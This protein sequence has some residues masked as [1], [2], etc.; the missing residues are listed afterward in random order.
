MKTERILVIDDDE[1]ARGLLQ[2]VLEHLGYRVLLA[3]SGLEA[4][5][6]FARQSEEVDLVILDL[7]MPVMSGAK[8]FPQLRAM[9]PGVPIVVSSGY[10]KSEA[11][12]RCGS[13]TDGFLQ[14]PFSI[15]QLAQAVKHAL[16]H[17]PCRAD[18][19]VGEPA[20]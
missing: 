7:T 18:G 2:A 17:V 20:F 15:A 6:L 19:H 13:S 1:A 4:L 16:E 8:V 12:H 14:K 5:D 11:V 10:D 3:G 9:R